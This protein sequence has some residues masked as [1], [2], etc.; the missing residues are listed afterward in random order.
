[1]LPC[2]E[3]L[4]LI[5]DRILTVGLKILMERIKIVKITLKSNQI[6]GGENN[7]SALGANIHYILYISFIVGYIKWKCLLC[8]FLAQSPVGT[9]TPHQ[10][11]VG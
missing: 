9:Y 1:M 5:T 11:P 8:V 4:L 2:K 6:K 7:I 10:A 3:N